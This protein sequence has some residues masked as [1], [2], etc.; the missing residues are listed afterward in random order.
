MT[1]SRDYG[2]GDSGEVAEFYDCD[3]VASG[4]RGEVMTCCLI[5]VM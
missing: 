1:V 5:D 4:F 3:E 2:G